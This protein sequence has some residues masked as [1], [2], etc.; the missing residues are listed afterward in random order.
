MLLHNILHYNSVIYY[1]TKHCIISYC[2]ISYFILY[3]DTKKEEY[4][5]M[6]NNTSF[7]WLLNLF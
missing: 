4:K 5:N 2:I 3:Y 6:F 7:Y 1:V